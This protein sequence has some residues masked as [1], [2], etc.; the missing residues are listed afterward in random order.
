MSLFKEMSF[1][2]AKRPLAELQTKPNMLLS[3]NIF[4][5][6]QKV[7]PIFPDMYKILIST[8]RLA[9]IKRVLALIGHSGW[10]ILVVIHDAPED[11]VPE[12][13]HTYMSVILLIAEDERNIPHALI[14]I[15]CHSVR[16]SNIQVHKPRIIN[17]RR[18][19]QTLR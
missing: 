5:I 14:H 16:R 2:F 10:I 7:L 11:G 1:A 8:A 6:H 9:H 3:I 13:T 15:H 18:M 4:R 19:L 12:I 17:I